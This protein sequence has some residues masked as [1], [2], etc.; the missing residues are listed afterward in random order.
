MAEEDDIRKI[1]VDLSVMSGE[2][3]ASA[4]QLADSLS[5][6]SKSL[7]AIQAQQQSYITEV[8]KTL[9]LA[10]QLQN[11]PQTQQPQ[12]PLSQMILPEGESR[13]SQRVWSQSGKSYATQTFPSSPIA[14]TSMPSAAEDAQNAEDTITTGWK[15]RLAQVRG[16]PNMGPEEGLPRYTIP[17]Y[18]R[19]TVQDYLK[20]VS[21]VMEWGALTSEAARAGEGS[22]GALGSIMGS[23]SPEALGQGATT[24]QTLSN[25]A[26]VGYTFLNP[27]KNSAQSL[28]QGSFENTASL[29]PL[30]WQNIGAQ[31]GYQRGGALGGFLP[32]ANPFSPASA[33]GLRQLGD[34]AQAMFRPGVNLGQAEAIR[35]ATTN[36]GFG[37][38][39]G[40][41]V[42]SQLLVPL[43]QKFEGNPQIFLQNFGASIRTGATNINQLKQVIDGLGTSAQAAH[44]NINDY[45]NAVGQVNQTF[46]QM[47]AMGSQQAGLFSEGFSNLSGLP[48][49]VGAQMLQSPAIQALMSTQSGLPPWMLATMPSNMALGALSNSAQ[50]MYNIFSHM[51]ARNITMKN[52]FGGP[53]ITETVSSQDQAYA[54]MAQT[55]GG[56]PQDWK[57]FLHGNDLQQK[58]GFLTGGTTAGGMGL[59]QNTAEGIK[60]HGLGSQSQN[61][62]D[63]GKYV[64]QLPEVF[65]GS[66]KQ[67]LNELVKAADIAHFGKPKSSTAG[68]ILGDVAGFFGVPGVVSHPILGLMGLGGSGS[69]DS[70]NQKILKELRQGN[71]SALQGKYSAQALQQL[72]SDIVNKTKN[73]TSATP[74]GTLPTINI[75]FKGQASKVF[76]GN[77]TG[78]W[79]SIG[80][81]ISSQQGG[82]PINNIYATPAGVNPLPYSIPNLGQIPDM[83]S[84]TADTTGAGYFG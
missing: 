52:P 72:Q 59:I 33:E 65:G 18:G 40:S 28:L 7:E 31:L 70:Y 35:A 17:R 61:I 49:T 26:G 69:H 45:M 77:A 54:M 56:N 29:N 83:Q 68:G 50:T 63:I 3:T 71:F 81:Q 44:M 32:V 79:S 75:A 57:Q 1:E 76:S 8:Q 64:S 9:Q 16:A 66:K 47:G 24:A 55:M 62:Q 5:T 11:Q 4:K 37:G 78:N 23:F 14:P 67:M 2:G 36:Y 60:L 42:M 82:T 13:H 80:A 21:N 38:S 73:L 84:S 39:L 74:N 20:E 25:W 12:T 6:I 19:L 41:N 30:K 27:L 22:S 58:V 48:P 46:Q 10:S 51:P 53:P 43:F 15:A 34:V